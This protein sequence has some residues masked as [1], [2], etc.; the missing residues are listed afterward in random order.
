[1][2]ENIDIV[3]F[4]DIFQH[5]ITSIKWCL[6]SQYLFD[7]FHFILVHTPTSDNIAQKPRSSPA[8]QRKLK[9]KS[10]WRTN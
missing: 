8:S 9:R 3:W 5:N 7:D 4:G 6:V 1:M 10:E 2:G